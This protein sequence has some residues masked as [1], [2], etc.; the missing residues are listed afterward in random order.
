MRP[1]TYSEV[2]G[3]CVHSSLLFTLCGSISIIAL[4]SMINNKVFS[5]ITNYVGFAPNNVVDPEEEKVER[6]ISY[7]SEINKYSRKHNNIRLYQG[8]RNK[9]LVNILNLKTHEDKYFFI[10]IV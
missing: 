5:E 10:G 1:F 6:K 3:S 2:T 4:G 8:L 7:N 9:V